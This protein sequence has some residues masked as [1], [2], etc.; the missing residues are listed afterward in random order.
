MCRLTKVS[1]I[2]KYWKRYFFIAR[3]FYMKS[4]SCRLAQIGYM[5]LF[6][7]CILLSFFFNFDIQCLASL[8]RIFSLVALSITKKKVKVY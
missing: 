1:V 3:Y 6:I 2:H 4:K 7:I 5:K 8:E